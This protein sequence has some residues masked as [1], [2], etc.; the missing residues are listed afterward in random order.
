M[1]YYR[2]LITDNRKYKQFASYNS[3]FIRA[4]EGFRNALS[5]EP[6]EYYMK[7][8]TKFQKAQFDM[9]IKT[10]FGVFFA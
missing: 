4:M 5:R 7:S 2:Q 6:K 1:I 9:V 3:A 10:Q 8:K